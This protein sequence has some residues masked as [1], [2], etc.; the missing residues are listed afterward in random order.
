MYKTQCQYHAHKTSKVVEALSLAYIAFVYGTCIRVVEACTMYSTR[1][2]VTELNFI[3]PFIR[4]QKFIILSVYSTCL[5]SAAIN[6]DI[7]ECVSSI[8]IK[9][10][11]ELSIY[12]W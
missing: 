7:S 1:T 6:T 10:S 2:E 4:V 8:H 11:L 12:Y 5:S 9:L 3:L